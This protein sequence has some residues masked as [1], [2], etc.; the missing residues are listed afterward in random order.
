MTVQTRLDDLR[1]VPRTIRI[2]ELEAWHKWADDKGVEWA[3]RMERYMRSFTE[4]GERRLG[5][6]R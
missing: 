5:Y 1:P 2:V 3:D 6:Y 4:P